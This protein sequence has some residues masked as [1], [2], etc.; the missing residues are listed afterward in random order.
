MGTH[1]EM[2]VGNGTHSRDITLRFE[3]F[4]LDRRGGL[5]RECESGQWEPIALGSRALEVLFALAKQH[6][7]LVT[8]PELMDAV[9]PEIAVGDN[10]L[11]VQISMLRRHLDEGRAEGSCIQT[12]IGR[13]Y[14][15]LPLVSTQVV[16]LPFANASM[17]APGPRPAASVVSSL[18][19]ENEFTGMPSVAVLPFTNLSD[20]REQEYFSDGVAD[21]IITELSRNRSLFVIARNSGFTYKSHA[22]DVRKVGLELDVRYVVQGSVRREVNRIRITAHLI[23]A[24]SG[25]LI[26]AERF[27]RDL[28]DF[29]AVQDEI[30]RAI[31]TAIDPAISHAEQERAMRKPP[32]SLSAWEAWQRALWHWSKGGDFSTARDFLLQAIAMDPRF[33]PPHAMLAWLHTTQ[34]TLAVGLPLRESVKLAE[35]EARTAIGLDP[36]SALAHAM[37]AWVFDHQ[38]DR[39]VALEESETAIALNANDPQGHLS[40]A[41]VLILSGRP[42]EAREPL[43]TALRLDPRGPTAP[44]VMQH[45]CMGCYLERDYIAAEVMSRRAMH[46]FPESPR[47][48]LWLTATLGQLGRDD[49]ARAALDTLIV[50]FP[51][52][53]KFITGSRP[54]YLRP[55]DHEHL[56]DGL[57]KA[58]WR[59]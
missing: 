59:A 34:S 21:D 18:P 25:T 56:L 45:R 47:P 42:A 41:R 54:A 23:D 44:S 53:F 27:D 29:F 14:R 8:K 10:N 16:A 58:D 32:G 37:L 6:G 52:Y 24:E 2:S 9:W 31:V 50:G 48:W 57:R 38:G 5:F 35:I 4:R 49:E 13:G 33:A 26:W 20:D 3:T 1:P 40:K 12:I 19:K 30:T 7:E 11:T 51:D 22:V 36:R 43:A 55:E 46:A 17:D 15:F 28:A 39:I